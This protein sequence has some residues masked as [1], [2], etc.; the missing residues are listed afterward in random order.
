MAADRQEQR[1]FL[2]RA[3][4]DLRASLRAV[5]T[6]AELAQKAPEHYDPQRFAQIVELMVDGVRKADSIVDALVNYALALRIHV[7]PMP[8]DTGVVLRGVLTS[9][10]AEIRESA[11][12]ITHDTLPQVT[13]DPDRLIQLFENLIRNA[14]RH[15]G[16]AAP[17]V[18]V[19]ARREGG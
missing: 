17:R 3:C 1:D 18:H 10:A 13:G 5:R 7:S 11:A 12:E 14:I 19:S 16:Q 4:H 2:L 8:V 15:G 9:M 6:S